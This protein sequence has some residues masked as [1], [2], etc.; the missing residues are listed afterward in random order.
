MHEFIALLRH[1]HRELF[2]LGPAV[3][4][5]TLSKY[6]M[7]CAGLICATCLCAAGAD[8]LRSRRHSGAMWVLS[9]GLLLVAFRADAMLW[10]PTVG[11]GFGGAAILIASLAV[12][13]AFWHEFQRYLRHARQERRK[14][15]R[16]PGTMGAP[17]PGTGPRPTRNSSR[18]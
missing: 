17:L 9:A 5:V 4:P 15:R 3:V 14:Y 2:L 12:L 10:S 1:I 8:Y 6:R 11:A 7:L 16:V 13:I 18:L